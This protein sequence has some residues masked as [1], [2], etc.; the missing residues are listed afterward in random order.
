MLDKPRV[1]ALIMAGGG[2]TR[3]WPASTPKRPKHL[4]ALTAGDPRSLLR[5]TFDRAL[6]LT[7]AEQIFVVTAAAQREQIADAL[8]ELAREQIIVEPEGRNTAACV[9][10]AVVY[11]QDLLQKRGRDHEQSVLAILPADHRIGRPGAFIRALQVA[12]EFAQ[13][14]NQVVTLGI[15]PDHPATGYGYIERSPKPVAPGVFAGLR[16]VE[17]PDRER[18]QTFVDSGRF[19]WNAGLFVATLGCLS[20]A[21]Q[22]HAHTIWEPLGQGAAAYGSDGFTGVYRQIPAIPFDIAVM[23][24]LAG[25]AVLPIDVDWSDLGTWDSVYAH[26]PKGPQGNAWLAAH[27]PQLHEANNCLIV[28]DGPRVAAL[29]VSAMAIV[30][31]HGRVMVCPLARAQEVRELAKQ[32]LADEP[33]PA[34]DPKKIV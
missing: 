5:Q 3:L 6:G 31:A 24:K 32:A 14:H 19:S 13:T 16:F 4:L 26:V 34:D 9:A 22:A 29:G 17:K 27:S 28:S 11:L 23:E 18:A 2:G 33:Q 20:R 25:F 21:F 12:A 8:P 7:P 10:L 1:Y 30:A 15:E